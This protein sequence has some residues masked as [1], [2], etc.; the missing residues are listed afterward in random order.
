MG[1][2]SISNRVETLVLTQLYQD[3]SYRFLISIMKKSYAKHCL[4]AI[5]IPLLVFVSLTPLRAQPLAFPGAEGFGRHALGGRGGQVLFVTNLN[6]QGPGSLRAAVD[7]EHPRMVVFNVAGTIELQS[8]LRIRHPRI[9][10]AGQS[11][12]GGGICLKKF[13]LLIS[14]DDVVV[15]F[16]RVRLGDEAG[17]LMDGI[18]I[19]YAENVIV[20]HCSVSWTLDEGVNT[21]HGTR[22]ITIQWCLISESLNDSLLRNGH[23]F[24]ASLGGVDTS[25]HHNLFA[26]HAGRNPS[27]A[28]ETSHPTINLDFRNNVIFNWENR[29]LDG[30][31]ESINVV[32]NYYKAGPA[33]RQLRSIVKMQCLDD[34]TFG[35]WHVKGNVLETSSGFS[36]GRALVIIDASDR[37]P[38]SVLIEQSVPFGPVSTD[39]PDLAYEKVCMHAGAIRPK[40]D[41]HDD[42]IVR[43]VQSGRT[44][45]GDGIISSQTEV[46]G[47]PKLLSARPKDDVDRD[48]MPDEWERLFHPNGDL[49]W[50]GIA[51]SDG[52][53]Y[54]DLE[55][56][57]NNTD[58]N[59]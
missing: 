46:G 28:G 45:F 7:A 19:S 12:P 42:R 57:L 58:P 50:D 55:E 59:K 49:S 15:R 32:N 25:Y 16:L 40:R 4:F 29:R 34:G 52:D 43:E 36:K 56:Y 37:L 17:K 54:T 44:T 48:G 22:N 35:R 23:G 2:A 26:N 27:I 10:I 38:E 9:T 39:T 30:R 3:R 8:A 53:G 5:W 18:D 51:D 21:Y 41:S 14:A 33:S 24:A 6:D 20:D 1:S 13:P 47:W 11:A 31:P